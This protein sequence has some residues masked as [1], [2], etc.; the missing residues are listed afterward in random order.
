MQDAVKQAYLCSVIKKLLALFICILLV[1][2]VCAQNRAI[3]SLENLLQKNI[4]NDTNKAILLN[5]TAY[6]IRKY[7]IPKMEAYNKLAMRISD[8]LKFNYGIA[9][10]HRIKGIVFYEQ[11]DYHK[12]I[13]SLE[14]ALNIF[15]EIENKDGVAKTYINI[16]NGYFYLNDFTQALY[17]YKLAFNAYRELNN[18][19]RMAYCYYC[20][21]H[22][23]KGLHD[24]SLLSQYFDK[25]LELTKQIN[26]TK[27][28][29]FYYN[30]MGIVFETIGNYSKA[31]DFYQNSVKLKLQIQDKLGL[32][33]TYNNIG[34]IYKILDNTDQALYYLEKSIEI[35]I[36]N[37]HERSLV[38]SY[39]SI[40]AIYK[41]KGNINK[42]MEYFK[43]SLQLSNKIDLKYGIVD[44][45]K[46]IGI[47]YKLKGDYFAAENY[48][49]QSLQLAKSL[50]LNDAIADNYY[51]LAQ[52]KFIENKTQEAYSF[53]L[54]SYNTAKKFGE[55]EIIK[56]SALLLSNCCELLALH[57]KAYDYMNTYKIMN[58][59]LQNSELASKLKT[60]EYKKIYDQE[61][62]NIKYELETKNM[63]LAKHNQL[64]WLSFSVL[65]LLT[66]LVLTGFVDYKRLKYKNKAL[67]NT[68]IEISNIERIE[69]ENILKQPRS[70]QAFNEPM[71]DQI[72]NLLNNDKLYTNNNLTIELLAD[73]LNTN[74]TYLSRVINQTFNCNFSSLINKYRINEARKL[75]SDPKFESYSIEGI[76]FEVGYNSK[77]VFN[78]AFKKQTGLT[79]SFYKNEMLK[80]IRTT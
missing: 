30:N 52:L 35:D 50:I 70:N 48:L 49:N 45:K 42:A 54:Q 44:A 43:T 55:A 56:K 7:N 37:N 26:D 28:L 9:E 58:D 47:I 13:N 10:S 32:S 18:I 27:Q 3:D 61:Q 75:L 60:I 64:K 6:A 16:G 71:V 39:S 2:C 46:N 69:K 33:D 22:A 72:N 23:Y 51:E 53:A 77:S 31:L 68:N 78:N 8:S 21:G 17:Y 59:S 62:L 74:R 15:K 36:Q 76:A 29:A 25:A 65:L 19:E 79:P 57:E 4:E 63:L 40:G 38:S 1:I 20:F 41:E 11:Y 34:L 73:K 80:N 14:K 66:L 5:K 12:T 24:Y 67:L